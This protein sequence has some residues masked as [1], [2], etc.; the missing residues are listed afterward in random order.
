MFDG[1][2]FFQVSLYL[3]LGRWNWLADHYVELN[4]KAAAARTRSS[5]FLKS[6]TKAIVRD[7]PDAALQA[8]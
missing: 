2:D 8:A 3:F 6:R 4:G 7:L 5:R 1:I